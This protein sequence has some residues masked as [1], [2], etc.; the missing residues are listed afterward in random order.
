MLFGVTILTTYVKV[1]IVGDGFL[2]R[3]IYHLST[4]LQMN[5]SDH[6]HREIT[7]PQNWIIPETTQ[8][9]AYRNPWVFA[10]KGLIKPS[11]IHK[12]HNNLDPNSNKR[13]ILR[14]MYIKY[15]SIFIL[16]RNN[17]KFQNTVFSTEPKIPNILAQSELQKKV[18]TIKPIR[19]KRSHWIAKLIKESQNI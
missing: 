2:N 6:R 10:T 17:F 16:S 1:K 3:H 19:Y 11:K 4:L 7:L 13:K 8:R 12:P 5:I 18:H 9:R 15:T 14:D